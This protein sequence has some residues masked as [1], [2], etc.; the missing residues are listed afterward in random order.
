MFLEAEVARIGS[1]RTNISEQLHVC[2]TQ[3]RIALM[4]K[5][6][7]EVLYKKLGVTVSAAGDDEGVLVESAD[8]AG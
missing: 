5:W 7:R 6:Q 1:G 8:G 2:I 3:R 4:P